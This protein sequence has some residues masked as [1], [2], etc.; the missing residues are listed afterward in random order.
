MEISIQLLLALTQFVPNA[1]WKWLP[2]ERPEDYPCPPSSGYWSVFS[3]KS[4]LFPTPLTGTE[5]MTLPQPLPQ[6]HLLCT[7]NSASSVCILVLKF[8]LPTCL[9]FGN[10]AFS[11]SRTCVCSGIF[12]IYLQSSIIQHWSNPPYQQ[13]LL[14]SPVLHSLPLSLDLLIFC[15]SLC[16]YYAVIMTSCVIIAPL[17]VC[18][19]WKTESPFLQGLA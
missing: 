3:R 19:F 1:G 13:I 6:M 8:H 15:A 5:Q 11:C 10:R 16:P 9:P 2:G 17:L 12:L 4:L 7:Q 18:F 14:L